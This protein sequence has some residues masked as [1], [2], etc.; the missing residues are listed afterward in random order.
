M[1][2]INPEY[3]NALM[4]DPLEEEKMARKK[5]CECLAD[6]Q[7]ATDRQRAYEQE[8][9]AAMKRRRERQRHS[10]QRRINRAT[11]LAAAATVIG[12]MIGVML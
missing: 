11:V 9:S 10:R 1:N 12:I 7:A 2:R 8:R 5:W 4:R 6:A 3:F